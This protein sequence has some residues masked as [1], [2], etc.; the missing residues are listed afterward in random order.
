MKHLR[1]FLANWISYDTEST[2]CLIQ[3]PCLADERMMPA[4]TQ[5]PQQQERNQGKVLHTDLHLADVSACVMQTSAFDVSCSF[6]S[7]SDVHTLRL[8]GSV[9]SGLLHYS[10]LVF[11][12]INDHMDSMDA[13]TQAHPNLVHSCI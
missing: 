8:A 1:M 4:A 2:M 5:I 9:W 3:L 10:K 13:A 6:I 11:D 12:H 7:A